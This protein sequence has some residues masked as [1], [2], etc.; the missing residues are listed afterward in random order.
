MSPH[1]SWRAASSCL[2]NVPLRLILDENYKREGAT[3]MSTHP[4]AHETMASAEFALPRM[5]HPSP[6]CVQRETPHGRLWAFK[7]PTR[8]RASG[9]IFFFLFD[10]NVVRLV[11]V[12]FAIGP[13][14]GP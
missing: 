1:G 5:A 6:T 11:D 13:E 3:L 12:V 4:H 2:G 10:E 7:V 8:H 14:S 9:M